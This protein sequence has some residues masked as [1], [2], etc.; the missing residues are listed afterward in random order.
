M[1]LFC[2]NQTWEINEKG[3]GHEGNDDIAP[4]AAGPLEQFL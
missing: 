3:R 2:I 4:G 1:F